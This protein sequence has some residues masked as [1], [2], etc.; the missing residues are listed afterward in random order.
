MESTE[1]EISTSKGRF[2]ILLTFIVAIAGLFVLIQTLAISMTSGT[3]P[4]Y[5]QGPVIT[6]TLTTEEK[7]Q[8]Y[9]EAHT[10]QGDVMPEATPEASE[11]VEEPQG[12]HVGGLRR[13]VG[14]SCADRPLADVRVRLP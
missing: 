11:A 6:P 12:A 13:A 3:T 14:S 7:I 2:K 8:E 5:A 10:I 9:I 4:T 1:R